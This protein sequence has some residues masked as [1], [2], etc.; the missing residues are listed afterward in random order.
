MNE[1]RYETHHRAMQKCERTETRQRFLVKRARENILKFKI[2]NWI[3]LIHS[4]AQASRSKSFK[5]VPE[6]E[7]DYEK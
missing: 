6:Q 5:I 7:R 3:I 1:F 2:Y 4:M